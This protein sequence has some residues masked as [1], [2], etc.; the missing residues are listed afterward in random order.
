[1]IAKWRYREHRQTIGEK[2]RKAQ[3]NL[4]HAMM[5]AFYD[6]TLSEDMKIRMH[7]QV[8]RVE[9]LFGYERGSWKS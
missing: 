6:E 4:M 7:E 3:D 8:K 2:K 5:N 1:M 9:K